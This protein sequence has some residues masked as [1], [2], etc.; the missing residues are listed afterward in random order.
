[1]LLERRLCFTPQ[2]TEAEELA[3]KAPP[4]ALSVYPDKRLWL[5]LCLYLNLLAVSGPNNLFL[6][7][8]DFFNMAEEGTREVSE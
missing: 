4:V 5:V 2:G 8:G 3:K 1:M 7:V 6:I